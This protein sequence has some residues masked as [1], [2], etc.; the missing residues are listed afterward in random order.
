MKRIIELF[1]NYANL[2]KS[3][4]AS[5]FIANNRCV[6]VKE[7]NKIL[8]QLKSLYVSNLVKKFINYNLLFIL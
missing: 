4:K 5:S 8:Q 6:N 3:L 2:I 7:D 1:N